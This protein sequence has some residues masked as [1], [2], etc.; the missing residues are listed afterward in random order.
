MTPKQFEGIIVDGEQL[1]QEISSGKGDKCLDF[2]TGN[3]IPIDQCVQE[4]I[5]EGRPGLQQDKRYIR[6]P[7][8]D[9]AS[10]EMKARYDDWE[11]G[12]YQD[13]T[14][15]MPNNPKAAEIREMLKPLLEAVSKTPEYKEWC[16]VLHEDLA[17]KNSA[18]RWIASLR[19]KV[20]VGWKEEGLGVTHV[21]VPAVQSWVDSM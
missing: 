20:M 21:Y 12:D 5:G 1:A 4:G 3:L 8:L 17:A 2:V 14:D 11:N 18:M 13:N 15:L 9:E 6:I 16:E 7:N 10:T 19:P